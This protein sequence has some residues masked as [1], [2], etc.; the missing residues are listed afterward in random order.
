MIAKAPADELG[1]PVCVGG[2]DASETLSL[3][4]TD[5]LFRYVDCHL[6]GWLNIIYGKV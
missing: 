6:V 2:E 3:A 4:D 1:E 5:V